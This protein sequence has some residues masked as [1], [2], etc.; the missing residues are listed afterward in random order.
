MSKNIH[1]IKLRFPPK[2][3]LCRSCK[4]AYGDRR[5]GLMCGITGKKPDFYA[6]CPYFDLSRTRDQMAHKY[7]TV[8][9]ENRTRLLE[10]WTFML[11][12]V[13]LLSPLLAIIGRATVFVIVALLLIGFSIHTR[14]I[15]R[16]TSSLPLFAYVYIV[17]VYLLGKYKNFSH[18]D[19]QIIYQTLVR[20]YGNEVAQKALALFDLGFDTAGKSLRSLLR[21]MSRWDRRFLYTLLFQLFVYDNIKALD[22]D[23]IMEELAPLFG[24]T[25]DEYMRLKEIYSAKEYER[26]YRQYRDRDRQAS[27]TTDLTRQFKILGLDP[28]ATNEEVKRRF[29]QLAK[30]YH[31]DRQPNPDMAQEAQEHFR[32]ILSAYEKI[33]LARGIK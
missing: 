18:D 33:K 3:N 24:I 15:A 4:Y 7:D 27:K 8:K 9:Q 30:M 32:L 20:F 10:L 22:N 17:F 13:V 16:Q 1:R 19:K 26:M 31:P 11:I 2:T 6:F 12:F 5:K 23:N 29:R 21:L 14:R 28:S 25:T